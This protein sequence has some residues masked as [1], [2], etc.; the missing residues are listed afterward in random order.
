MPQLR[1][2]RGTATSKSLIAAKSLVG[3]EFG[4][5]P[6]GKVKSRS[7][8]YRF[9]IALDSPIEGAKP[10]SSGAL[11]RKTLQSSPA[12][13]STTL[14]PVRFESM[15]CE[16]A[17]IS[18]NFQ[19]NSGG[20]L[21]SSDCVAEQEGFE[22]SVRFRRTKP[23]HIRKLQIAKPCQRFHVKSG[24]QGLHSVRFRFALHSNPKTKIKRFFGIT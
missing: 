7:P 8:H 18:R 10:D 6:R 12:A 2:G 9:L 23:P 19:R 22:P 4:K 15:N 3:T 14:S 21:C 24:N 13:F 20:F 1:S 11:R 5:H 16:I 17:P